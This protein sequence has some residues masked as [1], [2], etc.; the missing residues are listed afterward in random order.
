VRIFLSFASEQKETAELIAGALRGRGY[1]VF[2]SKDTLPAAESYDVRIQQA[3]RM[4]DLFIF[5]VSPEAVAKGKYTLTEL[6]FAREK[7]LSPSSHVLPVMIAPTPIG[8]I[9][10]FLR[11]VS[12]FEPEGNVAADTAAEADKILQRTSRRTVWWLAVLGV[13]TGILSQ[14]AFNYRVLEVPLVFNVRYIDSITIVPGVV[15]GA[16]MAYLNWVFGART[17]FQLGVILCATVLSWVLAVNMTALIMEKLSLYTYSAPVAGS[18][19][20]AA[21]KDAQAD[22]DRAKTEEEQLKDIEHVPFR[23]AFS[24]MIGGLVG[25]VGTLLGAALA[26]ERVRRARGLLQIVVAAVVLGAILGLPGQGWLGFLVGV[27]LF[28]SWQG[29]FAGMLGHALA[30]TESEAS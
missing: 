13:A 1:T 24:G 4:S 27:L 22:G 19:S 20:D 25:A 21:K 3:V 8:S 12:I 23:D 28:S 29:T 16:L 5:L 14:V 7:W 10:P 6:S 2:F 18:G 26:N 9:P 30:R 17:K 11:S 15:F